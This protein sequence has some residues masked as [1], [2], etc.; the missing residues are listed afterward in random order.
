MHS[1]VLQHQKYL[2]QCDSPNPHHAV[3]N[4]R[5]R[6]SQCKKS[7]MKSSPQIIS[8]IKAGKRKMYHKGLV[9]Y[10][11]INVHQCATAGLNTIPEH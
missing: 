8:K 3:T 2:K 9:C 11:L 6:C 4:T 7:V 1:L 5:H 10:N